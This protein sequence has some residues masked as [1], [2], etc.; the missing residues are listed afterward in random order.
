MITMN[1]INLVIRSNVKRVEVGGDVGL[2]GHLFR[3]RLEEGSAS[4]AAVRREEEDKQ[5]GV[6]LDICSFI[7]LN[8]C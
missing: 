4:S 7:F 6:Y 1:I 2:N 8:S 3:R 5:Q